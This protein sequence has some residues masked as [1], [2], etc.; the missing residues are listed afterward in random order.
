MQVKITQRALQNFLKSVLL[1]VAAEE[2]FYSPFPEYAG[3]DQDLTI[4]DPLPIEA[5]EQMATQIS[6]ERPPIEDPD[7]IPANPEELGLA[8]QLIAEMVPQAG[9][10]Y[11]Y[12]KLALIL[13]AAIDHVREHPT[14]ENVSNACHTISEQVEELEA[15]DTILADLANQ[16]GYSGPSGVRQAI[17][18]ILSRLGS[19]AEKMTDEELDALLEFARDEFVTALSGGGYIEDDDVQEMRDNPQIV[20]GLDSFRFFLVGSI[21]L[22]AYRALNREKRKSLEAELE[23][24]NLPDKTTTLMLKQ[25]MNEKPQSRAALEKQIVADAAASGLGEAAIQKQ[26]ALARRKFQQL[27]SAI[28]DEENL[29]KRAIANWTQLGNSRRQS[30]LRQALESTTSYQV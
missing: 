13:D 4:P 10:E 29:L 8:A 17:E 11:F 7:Y 3:E 15:S 1:E 12:K 23:T 2:E 6:V 19:V 27:Q 5:S 16:F 26:L 21:I 24:L 9:V 22:P 25:L 18:R 28:G 14:N 30:M 20:A